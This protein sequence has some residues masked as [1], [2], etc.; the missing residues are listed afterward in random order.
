MSLKKAVLVDRDPKLL[1]RLSAELARGGIAVE[2]LSS[3][4]GLTPD[5]LALSAP[6]WLVVDA[7]LPGLSRPARLV[8]VRSRKARLPLLRVGVTTDGDPAAA[9][10]ACGASAAVSRGAL[11]VEGARPLGIGAAGEVDVRA[12]ID[13]VLGRAP[14]IKGAQRYEIA[15]DLFSDHTFWIGRGGKPLGVFVATTVQPP[16]GEKV[17]LKLELMGKR[18]LLVHGAVAWQRSRRAFGAKQP[19]GVGIALADLSEEEKLV[20][21]RFLDQREPLTWIG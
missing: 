8:V 20:V 1:D 10:Q 13:G 11:V 15:V 3:T 21:D 2:A 5:L 4:S 18:T 17:E 6:D 7:E 16:V 9:Q 19:P 12:I 14:A